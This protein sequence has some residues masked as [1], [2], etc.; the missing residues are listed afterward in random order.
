MRISEFITKLQ[1]IKKEYGDIS[2]M[3]TRPPVDPEWDDNDP[4]CDLDGYINVAS[5][6]KRRTGSEYQITYNGNDDS[7]LAMILE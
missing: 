6:V 1:E 2:V 5:V 4:I 3:I 7:E